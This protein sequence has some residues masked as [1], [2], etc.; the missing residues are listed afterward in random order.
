MRRLVQ[1]RGAKVVPGIDLGFACQQ[2][3]HH[4]L[5]PLVRRYAQRPDVVLVLG[6]DVGVVGEQQLRHILMAINRRSYSSDGRVCS[7][8]SLHS[9][10]RRDFNAK[11]SACTIG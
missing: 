10:P 11:L 8:F 5:V 3:F 1:R 4:Y 7:L 6:I 9:R 2:Q